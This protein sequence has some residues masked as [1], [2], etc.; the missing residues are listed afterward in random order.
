MKEYLLKNT[1]PAQDNSLVKYHSL[2]RVDGDWWVSF[3]DKSNEPMYHYISIISDK[4]YR[5][6]KPVMWACVIPFVPTKRAA[7]KL[8]KKFLAGDIKEFTLRER[9]MP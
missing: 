3:Y 8:V 7:N 6:T 1:K 4:V 9:P 5:S 2:R